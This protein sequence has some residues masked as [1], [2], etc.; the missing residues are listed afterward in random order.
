MPALQ[1]SKLDFCNF[2]NICGMKPET[3]VKHGFCI[4]V[5]FGLHAEH[6]NKVTEI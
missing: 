1:W 4:L 3:C 6:T 5:E 2:I